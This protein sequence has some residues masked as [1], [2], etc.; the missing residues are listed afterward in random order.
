MPWSATT[1]SIPRPRGRNDAD[2]FVTA[3]YSDPALHT[4]REITSRPV[5][6]IGE[7]AILTALTLGARFGT[8]TILR[9]AIAPIV[10]TTSIF[11][12]AIRDV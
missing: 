6:G 11:I 5:F 3:C 10:G 4:L 8:I 1:R 2:A 12:A 7:S 9:K